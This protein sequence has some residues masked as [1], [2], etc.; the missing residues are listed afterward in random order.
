MERSAVRNPGTRQ[1][2]SAIRFPNLE[3][4]SRTYRPGSFPIEEFQ[5]QNGAVTAVKFANRKKD[6][7]L[8]MT[9]QNITDEEAFSIWSN[10]Q[11]VMDGLDS[12]GDWNYIEF[13][14]AD[15]GAMAGIKT[16]TNACCDGRVQSQPPLPLRRRTPI[17]QHFP[18]PLHRNHQTAWLL[19][20]PSKLG[21]LRSIHGVLQR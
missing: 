12:N 14:K 18:R 9:F 10:H 19:R 16:P 3:P 13:E 15:A 21:L 7:E 20:R 11:E 17:R 8:T 4:S 6:S 1:V 2:M 5:G